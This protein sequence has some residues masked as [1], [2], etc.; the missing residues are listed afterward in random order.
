MERVVR[1]L[2]LRQSKGQGRSGARCS[3]AISLSCTLLFNDPIA[4]GN[5]GGP[6]IQGDSVSRRQRSGAEKQ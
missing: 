4:E 1:G 2:A 6:D 5:L 3:G